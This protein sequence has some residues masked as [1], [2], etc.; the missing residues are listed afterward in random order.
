MN[1]QEERQ[2][3]LIEVKLDALK[4]QGKYMAQRDANAEQAK[5]IVRQA[6]RISE[7]EELYK[8]AQSKENE[9]RAAQLAISIT[10]LLESLQR[11]LDQSR[12]NV[13]AQIERFKKG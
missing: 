9:R 3:A 4:W 1:D 8:E 10:N 5:K 11:S 2:L 6:A 12:D 7:L 13:E